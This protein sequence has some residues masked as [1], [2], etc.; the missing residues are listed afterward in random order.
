MINNIQEHHNEEEVQK[1]NMEN[2]VSKWRSE[3]EFLEQEINFYLLL[4][5]SSLI[6]RTRSNHID[7]KYLVKQFH[8]LKDLNNFHYKTCIQFQNKL[9][10]IEECDDVQCDNAYL[11]SFLI[12]KNKLDTHFEVVRTIKRSAFQYLQNGI[13]A[14]E[15]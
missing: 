1:L 7:A 14:Y 5:T 3:L 2:D 4:L 11:N 6:E 15:N 9:Q 10:G 8:E 13:E 12:F